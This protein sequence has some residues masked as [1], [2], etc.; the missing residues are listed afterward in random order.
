MGYSSPGVRRRE[1]VTQVEIG[2][3]LGIPQGDLSQMEN[4]KRSIGKQTAKRLTE[5]LRRMTDYFCDLIA[6]SNKIDIFL[7]LSY[8]LK[9]KELILLIKF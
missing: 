6:F 9:E 7:P 5:F 2:K 1:C 4:G 3:Q 8:V